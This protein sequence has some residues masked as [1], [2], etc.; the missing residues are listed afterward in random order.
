MLAAPSLFVRPVIINSA[1]VV[2]RTEINIHHH[3]HLPSSQPPLFLIGPG[4]D[5]CILRHS[6]IKVAADKDEH[7]NI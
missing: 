4:F 7:A 5:S 6:G 1:G 2:R 3:G